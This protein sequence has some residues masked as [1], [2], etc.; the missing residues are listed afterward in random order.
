[1]NTKN[2]HV[3][4]FDRVTGTFTIEFEGMTALNY[5]APRADGV[6]LTGSALEDYIQSLHPENRESLNTAETFD[7][8]M[9]LLASHAPTDDPS[10]LTG[11]DEI[12]A[13]IVEYKAAIGWVEPEVDHSV[14]LGE[15][16]PLPAPWDPA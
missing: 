13:K 5:N 6:Y 4:A 12:E 7:Q 15:A 9:A 1:M 10:G 2:Y 11:G 16:I 3:T 14:P 8:Y